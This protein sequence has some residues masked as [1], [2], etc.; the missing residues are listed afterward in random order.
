MSQQDESAI[1]LLQ[2]MSNFIIYFQ[3]FLLI[4]LK[5]NR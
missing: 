3:F 1:T 5:M 4:D 2:Q